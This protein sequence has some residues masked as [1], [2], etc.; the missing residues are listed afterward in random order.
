MF[1]IICRQ[2]F[3][4]LMLG[5]YIEVKKKKKEIDQGNWNFLTYQL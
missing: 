3:Y 1:V 5:I 2:Y 4:C